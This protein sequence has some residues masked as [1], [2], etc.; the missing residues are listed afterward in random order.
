[1]IGCQSHGHSSIY[2][3]YLV[4]ATKGCLVVAPV[5]ALLVAVAA[6]AAPCAVAAVAGV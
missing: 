3:D 5:V 6:V 2:L 4:M 1:M